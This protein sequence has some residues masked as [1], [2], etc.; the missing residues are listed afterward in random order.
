M[1]DYLNI[2]IVT[3]GKI[4]KSD[5]TNNGLLF[6][7]LFNSWPKN[8]ISQIYNSGSNDDE[9]FW[10]NYYKLN[11]NDRRLGKLYL[12][13][14]QNNEISTIKINSNFHLQKLS[15]KGRLIQFSKRFFIKTGIYELIFYPRLSNELKNWLDE[16]KPDI[17]L[18]Q[19][20]SI[21]F[22]K[23]PLLIKKYTGAKLAFF[24]TDDWPKYLY[25]G[26]H[27]ELKILSFLPNIYLKKLT[28]KFMDEVNIPIAFGYPM[29]VEYTKRY[30][31]EFH[32]IIHAD[33]PL[34]FNTVPKRLTEENV[35]SIVTIGSFNKYRLPLLAD[36]NKS[37]QV[38]NSKGIKSQ[39]QVISDA[40]DSD[41]Y[42][43][44]ELMDYVRIYNDPGSDNLPALLKG[45]DLLILIETFDFHRA[46]AIELSIS[47]K[48]HLYMFSRVPII[49]YSHPITGIS[50]YAKEYNWAYI[51]NKR[52]E[53]ELTDA[54]E[55]LLTDNNKRQYLIENAYNVA[56]NKHNVIE[57]EKKLHNILLQRDES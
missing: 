29:Q 57:T 1:K 16:V 44:L 32:S 26:Y 42:A 27:G 11:Q 28:K 43:E 54:I 10:G 20:Y 45:A 19:G 53:K 31:K 49:L 51:V 37:C 40:I 2:C 6:R 33:N 7:S 52:D 48:A 38:L 56:M 21:T 22:T 34:R 3:S 47:T 15:F 12:K 24:T 39:V 25:Y 9:G 14:Y 41:G 17:I 55:V 23:L 4:N 8:N 50:K 35:F 46:K 5:T 36:L 18:A 30:G 13:L